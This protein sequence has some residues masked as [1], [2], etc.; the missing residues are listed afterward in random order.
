MLEDLH[1][2]SKF[3]SS[4]LWLHGPAGAGKS[5]I[6]QSFCQQ[7]AEEGHLGASFFFKRGDGSRGSGKRL[8]STIAYQ[9]ALYLPD[10]KQIISQLVEDDPSILER[11]LSTQLQKL[12][13]EPCQHIIWSRPLVV[14]ID[15][16][17]ECGDQSI[18][19]EIL[20]S[21]GRAIHNQQLP[22]PLFVASRPEPHI[23]E[24]FSSGTL[25]DISRLLNIQ[26]SFL[27]VH[28]YLEDELARV[29]REHWETMA[30]VPE[31]WPSHSILEKLTDKS[32]GYFVYAATV[33]RFID[34]RDFRP[35]ERLDM[36]MGIQTTESE[37]PFAALDELY[38]QILSAVPASKHPRLLEI[39][40]VIA[41]KFNLSALHIEQLLEFQP[42]DARLI[43]RHL[44][45]VLDIPRDAGKRISVHHASFL[46]F[47]DDPTRSGVFHIGELQRTNLAHHILKALS[48]E[49]DSSTDHVA[50]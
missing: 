15:G 7:L 37:T 6:A 47:L 29:H 34:D 13:I 22:F 43:L 4:V 25:K 39:L 2:W 1:E 19:R 9:L 20:L 17:D 10:L 46:D 24:I 41:A 5:A 11:A 28:I 8:F 48:L 33:V 18:Q 3:G 26:Q 27:D 40:A 21:L 23:H 35:T 30:M 36:I 38:I 44:H 12:I 45:S 31:P 32:S 50:W 16:L 14:V 42:G 49:I